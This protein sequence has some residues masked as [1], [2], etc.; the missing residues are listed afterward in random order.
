MQIDVIMCLRSPDIKVLDLVVRRIRTQ[1]EVKRV[2]FMISA[3]GALDPFVEWTDNGL[4]HGDSIIHE[5]LSLAVARRLG[6]TAS[7]TEFISF[8][9]CDVLIPSHF[10]HK[11]L[12]YLTNYAVV[13]GVNGITIDTEWANPDYL[14]WRSAQLEILDRGL[15]TA[16]L[17][18]RELVADWTPPPYLQALEDFHLTQHLKA[19]RKIWLQIPHYIL[20]LS[21]GEDMK[22]RWCWNAAGTRMIQVMGLGHRLPFGWRSSN[23]L[24]FLFWRVTRILAIPELYKRYGEDARIILFE[25]LRQFYTL[26]GYLQYNRFLETRRTGLER[27]VG[28]KS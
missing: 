27:K 7:T 2:I 18:R 8:V 20:H 1:P 21:F 25:V 13:G 16:N 12:R 24:S 14:A 10:Y 11:C 28:P 22:K 17:I 5:D 23:M 4:R 26:K 19:K 3:K 9:D 6:I 15:C